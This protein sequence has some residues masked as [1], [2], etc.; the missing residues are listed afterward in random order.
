MAKT[1]NVKLFNETLF[2]IYKTNNI[3][4]LFDI[5]KYEQLKINKKYLLNGDSDDEIIKKYI[6]KW[7]TQEIKTLNIKSKYGS[8]K[9]QLL[10]QILT[11]YNPKRVLWIT[12]RQTLTDNINDEF[13]NYGFSSYLDNIYDGNRQIIQLESIHKLFS[14]ENED[15]IFIDDE[16]NEN[17]V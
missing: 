7:Q 6:K 5:E 15:D 11:K 2:L 17:E 16:F 10:K 3:N 14:N 1:D 8:G 12:Y 9:T 4:S 13:K